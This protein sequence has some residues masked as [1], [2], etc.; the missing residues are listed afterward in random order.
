MSD[1]RTVPLV[2]IKQVRKANLLGKK[3]SRVV[4]Q[5]RLDPTRLASLLKEITSK[6]VI[7]SLFLFPVILKYG[8]LACRRYLEQLE[9]DGTCPIC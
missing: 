9:P 1:T 5:V 4:L 7:R 6:D 8:M 3:K 2:R